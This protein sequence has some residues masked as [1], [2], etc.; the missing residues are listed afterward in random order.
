MGIHAD[1]PKQIVRKFQNGDIIPPMPSMSEL[2][3]FFRQTPPKQ[4]V[5][6][7]PG[8]NEK[9]CYSEGGH[10]Y[11]RCRPHQVEYWAKDVERRNS[12]DYKKEN[13][14]AGLCVEE[15]C[16]ELRG[17]ALSGRIYPRCKKHQAEWKRAANAATQA[18]LR[19]K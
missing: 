19:G 18:R 13:P 16:Y 4:V 8:C 7:E 11:E 9:R 14:K 17:I 3:G 6:V 2:A 1:G 5:C 15:G 10:R 12:P